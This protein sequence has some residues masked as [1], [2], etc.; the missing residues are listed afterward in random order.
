M[1][2][3]V[4]KTKRFAVVHEDSISDLLRGSYVVLFAPIVIAF[5]VTILQIYIRVY[6]VFHRLL[7]AAL[8]LLRIFT[9]PQRGRS[10]IH[11]STNHIGRACLLFSKVYKKDIFS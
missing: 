1:R 5:N 9:R 11:F 4:L 3:S 10:E 6:P 8:N 7:V 2:R